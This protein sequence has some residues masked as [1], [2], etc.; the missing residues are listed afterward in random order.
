MDFII[1]F[2]IGIDGW[3][4]YTM[5]VVNTILI[6]AIIGY[7]GEKK[8]EEILKLSMNMD[9]TDLKSGTMNLNPGNINN[10]TSIPTVS[11]TQA[12]S[13]M[14]SSINNNPNINPIP[15]TQPAQGVSNSSSVP[16]NQVATPVN[17][18]INNEI[19]P[20]EKAPAVLIINSP[21]NNQ[22]VK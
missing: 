18:P 11:A 7:L 10:S 6:F 20:N 15:A 14:P 16:L 12:N 1:D 21:N 8:N 22:D 4:Y 9:S 3:I 19:D 17:K 13:A 5:L 2:F